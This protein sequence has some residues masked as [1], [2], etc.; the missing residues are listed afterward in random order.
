[1]NLSTPDKETLI[2]YFTTKQYQETITESVDNKLFKFI[3]LP[4]LIILAIF[5]SGSGKKLLMGRQI[6]VV[7]V[8]DTK[9]GKSAILSRFTTGSFDSDIT[10]TIGASYATHNFSSPSGGEIK[11]HIWDTAGQEKFRSLAPM[12]YRNSN[13][14]LLVYDVT[15]KESFEALTVWKKE[16]DTKAPVGIKFVIVGNKID[17]KERAVSTEEG[18]KYA[19]AIK[20]EFQESSAKSG[21]GVN[22]IFEKIA[23]MEIDDPEIIHEEP[24]S[25]VKTN[26]EGRSCC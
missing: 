18:M 17:L 14:A 10:P 6:K 20:A 26:K 24:F 5:K 2:L 13:V 23:I 8:G 12:Y 21:E 25:H 15:S 3:L 1:M 16:I 7:L 11:I 9:V 22:A 4:N 19:N